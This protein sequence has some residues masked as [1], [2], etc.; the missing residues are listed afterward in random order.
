MK[1]ANSGIDLCNW[2]GYFKNNYYIVITQTL[3][4]HV[5]SYTVQYHIERKT[6]YVESVVIKVNYLLGRYKILFLN[7]YINMFPKVKTI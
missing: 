6:E 3:S 4:C 1:I 7:M 2:L 5:L